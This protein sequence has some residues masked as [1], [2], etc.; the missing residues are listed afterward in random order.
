MSETTSEAATLSGLPVRPDLL[1]TVREAVDALEALGDAPGSA[2]HA[3]NLLRATREAVSALH[4]ARA[5]S[6]QAAAG[7]IHGNRSLIHRVLE[8]AARRPVRLAFHAS[9]FADEWTDL[10]IE[11]VLVSDYTVGSLVFHRARSLGDRTLFLLPPERKEGRISWAQA[12]RRILDIGRSLLAL[13]ARAELDASSP[14]ALLGA[15]SP[16]LALFDLACLAT[17]TVN[18]PIPANAPPSQ[19][20]HILEHAKPGALFLGDE[21]ARRA[22]AEASASV[23][24]VHWLV[25]AH[26]AVESTGTFA[27][28]LALGQG[29]S[30]DE[31]RN[32]AASAR[33][34]DVATVMYTSGTTGVPKAVPFTHG[35][36]VT[37]RFARAAAWPDLGEGDVFLCY[38]PL[39]HTF[40]RWLEMLGCVFWGSMYAFVEDVSVQSLL[41]S[42]QRV[43]PTTFVSVPK[44]WIQIA[45]AVAPLSADAD[46][47][48]EHD[49]EISR[50]LVEATG[51]R[52]KRGLSAA[53]YLPVSVFRRFHAA[54]IELHSGFGMTEATGGVTMTPIG[55]YR[56]DSI[57]TALPGIELKVASDGE[58]LLR[59]PYVTAATP[60][61]VSREDGWLATGDIVDVDPDGHYRIIDRKKEIFKNVQGETISPRRTESLFADFDAIDRVLLVGDG[62][63]YC[64]VLIVPSAELRE[65]YAK[66][67][68]GL[69]VDSPQLRDL[70]GPI[71]STVNRFLAPYERI[72]DFT[73]LAR[74][75]NVDRGELTA[76][77]T[78]RR[79]I[80]AERFREAI[81]PMYSRESMSLTAGEVPVKVP[82]WFLRQTGV[83]ARELR[84]TPD[85]LEVVTTGRRL[86]IRR[87]D[88][89]TVLVGELVYRSELPELLL[90]EVFGRAELWIGNE[91]VREFAGAGIEYWWRR[92]RRFKVATRLERRP[93]LGEEEAAS[94]PRTW[95]SD[96]GLDVGLLH[97]LARSL[98]H[99]DV[100]V[101]RS[102]VELLRES[103]TGERPEIDVLVRD[104]L[105]TG[106][107]DPGIRGECLRA[108]LPVSSAD[109][110]EELIE[111]HL[112]DSGFLT[113]RDASVAAGAPLRPDQLDRLLDLLHAEAERGDLSRIDRLVH[114][115]Q[116]HAI[117]HRDSHLQVRAAL[118][119]LADEPP[120]AGLDAYFRERLGEL[121]AEF[122]TKLSPAQL[123]PGTRWDEAVDFDE[124]VEPS[125][126]PRILAAFAETPLLAEAKILLGPS[127]QPSL[128]PL[129]PESVRIF[130]LGEGKGRTVYGIEWIGS[131]ADEDRFECI[132]K[133][134]HG[135]AWEEIQEELRLAVRVRAA[136]ARPIVKIH[137]GGYREYGLWTEE[138]VPGLTLDRLVDRLAREAAAFA[139][140]GD[141]T[142]APGGR[143]L[144]AWPY[145]VSRCA[146]LV[147]DFWR[148]TGCKWRLARPNPAK[149]VLPEHDWQVG[150]RLVS[151][152][153]RVRCRRLTEVLQSIHHEIVL[154]LEKRHPDLQLPATW[155]YLF[156]A[157]LEVLGEKEGIQVLESE[158]P[159]TIGSVLLDPLEPTADLETLALRFVSSVKRRGFLPTGIRLA[160]RRWRGWEQLNPH[161]T[162][163]AQAATLDQVEEAYGLEDVEA[164]RPGS[165]LQLFRHTA[166]R[167]APEALA[168]A[169]DDIIARTVAGAAPRDQ[170]RVDVAQLR[171]KLTLD[172]RAEF[173]LAR[174]L[175][176]HLDPRGRAVLLREEDPRGGPAA[177]VEIE[178]RDPDG[179]IF[180]IRRP[181][182]PN[183]TN[184]L[185][186]I[187]RASNFRRVPTSP[188]H[189]LLVVTEER[190][191]VIGGLI[192]R[193]PSETW[194]LLEWIVI[195]RHRRGKALGTTLMRDFL[196]R[197]R[198]QGVKAV[199]TGFF[200]PGFFAKF[201]FGVDP[202]YAGIVKL[203]TDE[204]AGE[205]EAAAAP[206]SAGDEVAS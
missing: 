148:R 190:G 100:E 165:R 197:L 134:N 27:D 44:K 111:R 193:R 109:D 120:R 167:G 108:I 11:A 71:V 91:E 61:D 95:A 13:R 41:W 21:E 43:R 171:G 70:F 60:E 201:G 155:S 129:G 92:G 33:S 161:A 2:V 104:V 47:D 187:F 22:A 68:A 195:G 178:Y 99:P 106:L 35:N 46:A 192:Y 55:D 154:P 169:L 196:E 112:A 158:A 80:L 102:I 126:R 105:A 3:A 59:G 72:V 10:A 25:E 114:W 57:G 205:S 202:R 5:G 110:L 116:R 6:D 121:V 40:G 183:E 76:K 170:W 18:V 65:A 180:R 14:V 31:V 79:K 82:H 127:P 115:L 156:A 157:A 173:F 182:N 135:T 122:R 54:G 128:P 139:P 131:G 87:V 153:D 118:A 140:L 81:E 49:R 150:G 103:P 58:L 186:R 52:L 137:G 177:G 24:R 8:A 89:R 188:E 67:A 152:S 200:R 174:M 39:Y 204:P 143:L 66:D 32:A 146:T 12:E 136:S 151:A 84:A 97:E 28:F 132:L 149:V 176:P 98:R 144:E 75:L 107:T 74:D 203:L 179:E 168:S 15:N 64:T 9:P 90:G 48:R 172:A 123:A 163:E 117:E 36:V 199:S 119:G 145:L 93:L 124:D 130:Y 83:H 198:V 142:A 7:R 101:R 62:R 164:E 184:A 133:V 206:I 42:F 86:T 138:Y 37:K 53:G 77:G 166:F 29:V 16:E 125:V 113:E 20:Q 141:V 159:W 1:T 94:L 185:V 189:D 88:P 69:T 56:D 4:Q 30:D 181:A 175:Y 96:T 23:P 85:G 162:L 26:D 19:M 17:G 51:G 63:E 191:R 78:P 45:E 147:I 160:A 38:L 73:I 50:A 194:A 34:S